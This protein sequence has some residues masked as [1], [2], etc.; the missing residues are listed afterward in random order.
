M[1][2]LTRVIPVENRREALILVCRAIMSFR[3]DKRL[4][5]TLRLDKPEKTDLQTRALF[6]C[7]YKALMEQTGNDK[8]DLH[9]YFCGEFFS[10]VE[11]EVM[12]RKKLKPRRTTTR[13]EAG[14]RDPLNTT[15]M[16]EFYDFVQ[17][18]AGMN[19]FDV[20]DPDPEWFKQKEA[21]A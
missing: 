17:R 19:G 8:D 10:W 14:E 3:P 20:P 7:A 2:E 12:G 9:T 11:H 15:D 21:A 13:N 18:R 4:K 5:L 1:N 16:A 6:G